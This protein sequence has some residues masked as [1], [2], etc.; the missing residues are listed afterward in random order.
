MLGIIYHN[1]QFVIIEIYP[2]ISKTISF[3]SYAGVSDMLTVI[4]VGNITHKC[5]QH[6][7]CLSVCRDLGPTSDIDGIIADNLQRRL[8]RIPYFSHPSLAVLSSAP[9]VPKLSLPLLPASNIRLPRVPL[10]SF[11]SPR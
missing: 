8:L 10:D 7:I 5:A 2:R 6:S 4:L 3:R 9:L 11:T 1:L